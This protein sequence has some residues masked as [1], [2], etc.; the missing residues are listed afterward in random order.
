MREREGRLEAAALGYDRG[1]DAAPRVLARGRGEVADRLL[2]QAR[3]HG[4][5]VEKD[6]DLLECLRSLEVG[7]EIPVAAYQAVAEILAL[8][9]RING[10]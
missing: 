7:A 3:K 4:V 9:Y 1:F 2:E 6:P 10:P 8:L 5:P